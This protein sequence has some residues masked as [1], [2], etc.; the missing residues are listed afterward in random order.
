M[1]KNHFTDTG[2]RTC[3][4]KVW[5]KPDQ[6]L[7]AANYPFLIYE[8]FILWPFNGEVASVVVQNQTAV[9]FEAAVIWE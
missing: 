9:S 5:W 7:P 1:A 8:Y 3:R 2:T 6:A 4:P